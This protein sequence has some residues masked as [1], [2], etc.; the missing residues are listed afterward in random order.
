MVA[1]MNGRIAGVQ[2]MEIFPFVDG[3]KNLNAALL[4]GVAVHSD[5][6]RRGI[7]SALVKA[8]ELEAWRREAAFVTT[9]P[10]E[11]SRP[12][13]LKYGYADLGQRQLLAR[14][15]RAMALGGKFAP[16]LGHLVGAV[17]G[18]V[19]AVFKTIPTTGEISIR[20]TKAIPKEIATLAARH[21]HLFPGLRMHRGAEWLRWRF[22][23]SPLRKYRLLEACDLTGKLVGFAAA[24]LDDREKYRVCYLVDLFVGE[25]KYTAD[26]L[27]AVVNLARIANAEA[28]ATVVSSPA[29]TEALCRAGFWAAPDWLPLKRFYSV[30]K[31]NPHQ[32]A[33]TAW[34]TLAGWYQ[35]LADWDNL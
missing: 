14:P 16:V 20:E 29:L 31:F 32:S 11:K 19:Q 24:T 7:F 18:A 23:E 22:L 34:Q 15:V 25:K 6:R 27:R 13:F 21:E 28:V 1:D 12:G 2:P 17:G 35:T 10:N 4:T 30:A 3:K 5:F 33:P 9:M 8:C 26:F